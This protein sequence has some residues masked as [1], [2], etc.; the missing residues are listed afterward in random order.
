M[1]K[2]QQVFIELLTLS[3]LIKLSSQL[4][5]SEWYLPA[6]RLTHNANDHIYLNPFSSLFS[7]GFECKTS[8]S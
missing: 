1:K 4:S 5:S 8:S 3:G 7:P 6:R 2:Q